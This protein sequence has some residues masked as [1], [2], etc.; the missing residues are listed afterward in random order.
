[1]ITIDRPPRLTIKDPLLGVRLFYGMFVVGGAVAIACP[2][3]LCIDS[4]VPFAARDYM[5]I[6][7]GSVCLIVGLVLGYRSPATITVFDR[8]QG[9][10][11]ISQGGAWRRKRTR[12]MLADVKEPVIQEREGTEGTGYQLSLKLGDGELVPLSAHWAANR[13]SIVHA[14]AA[15][16]RYLEA[17]ADEDS[18]SSAV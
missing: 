8:E 16:S 10:V 15:I 11:S 14:A 18:A 3:G 6:V 7:I 4:A 5:A 12:L 1:M 2:L 9:V 17:G 13:G